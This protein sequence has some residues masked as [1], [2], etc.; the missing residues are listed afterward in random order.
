MACWLSW[1]IIAIIPPDLFFKLYKLSLT[2]FKGRQQHASVQTR[3]AGIKERGDCPEE[4]SEHM[5][6]HSQVPEPLALPPLFQD[7]GLSGFLPRPEGF[8]E[9][10]GLP[11]QVLSLFPIGL[12]VMAKKKG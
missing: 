12:L 1:G 11:H 5:N 6:D 8:Q 4:P 3:L 9:E 10:K 7:L 2:I